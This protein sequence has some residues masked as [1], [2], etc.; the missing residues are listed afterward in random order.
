MPGQ[1]RWLGKYSLDYLTPGDPSRQRQPTQAGKAID[2]KAIGND[3]L[4]ALK[5]FFELAILPRECHML[6][7]RSNK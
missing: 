5:R 6:D 7:I 4:R 2:R 3:N 1:C